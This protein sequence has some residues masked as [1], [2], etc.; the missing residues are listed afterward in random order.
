[1]NEASWMSY[2]FLN[3]RRASFLVRPSWKIFFWF[4]LLSLKLSSLPIRSHTLSW[5]L[6]KLMTSLAFSTMVFF[7]W[8]TSALFYYFFSS[9]A[10]FFSLLVIFLSRAI[11]L[12]ISAF[13]ISCI[14][15]L[16]MASLLFCASPSIYFFSSSLFLIFC[17]YC[18]RLSFVSLSLLVISN[19]RFFSVN[20]NIY[21]VSSTFSSTS[22]AF[23]LMWVI[24]CSLFSLAC[25][26]LSVNLIL[27][28]CCTS[29]C[30]LSS[31]LLLSCCR[32][33]IFSSWFFL[34]W[35]ICVL[36]SSAFCCR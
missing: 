31:L 22:W 19:W 24:S 10:F 29:S 36:R 14:L 35:T 21:F 34:F 30:S 26:I 18:S 23:L 13:L 28:T 6:T 12:L 33:L 25:R 32:A 8:R 3:L 27:F 9:A 20:C 5:S 11:Y 17:S 15:V 16:V 7:L 2:C 4:S 1:M